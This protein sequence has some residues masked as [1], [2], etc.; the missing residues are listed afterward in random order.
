MFHVFMIYLIQ[1]WMY[2]REY[3]L[4]SNSNGSTEILFSVDI[5]NLLSSLCTPIVINFYNDLIKM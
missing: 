1:S 2:N 4:S 5:T 3:E